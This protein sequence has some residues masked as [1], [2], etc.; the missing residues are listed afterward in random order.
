MGIPGTGVSHSEMLISASGTTRAEGYVE[1]VEQSDG[2]RK[3]SFLLGAGIVL[4]PYIF[5]WFT[6]RRGHT[7]TSRI[8]SFSWLL[9]IVY[10]AVTNNYNVNKG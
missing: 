3:V 10:T 1:N 6:L 2:T 5:A 4:M 7:F 8:V 9:F